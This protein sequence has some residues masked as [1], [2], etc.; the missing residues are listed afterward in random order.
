M[1]YNLVTQVRH[2]GTE[3]ASWRLM[4]VGTCEDEYQ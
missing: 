1:K 4:H 2:S 3:N